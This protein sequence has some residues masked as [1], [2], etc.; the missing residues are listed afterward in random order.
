MAGNKVK[1]IRKT[2]KKIAIP[3]TQGKLARHFGHCEEFHLFE[4]NNSEIIGEEAL[5]P[6]PHQPGTIPKWVH[7]QGTTDVIAGGMGQRAIDIFNQLGINVFV[8]APTVDSRKIVED[9][10]KGELETQANLCDH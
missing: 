10:L 7:Q 3:V 8:G 5:T 9:F 2:M 4:I 1:I 6:P